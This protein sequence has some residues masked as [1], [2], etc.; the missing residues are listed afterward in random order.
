MIGELPAPLRTPVFPDWW[1]AAPAAVAPAGE[2]VPRITVI[3]PS[4]NQAPFLEAT[5]RSVLSQ[6]YPNL[7]Y[8]VVDGGSRDGSVEIIKRYAAHLSSWVS[9]PDRGQVD[10][11]LKGLARATGEWVNWINSDDL[12]APGALGRVARASAGVDV[13]AGTVVNFSARGLRDATTCRRLSALS[14]IREHLGGAKFHQPG[15]WLRREA[16]QQTGINL[17]R[18]YKFDYELLLRYLHRFPRVRY[19][20]EVLAYFRLHEE[21]KTVTQGKNRVND[22]KRE[23]VDI[24]KELAQDADF[25]AL[26]G[27]LELSARQNAW[28]M[29][30]APYAATQESRWRALARLWREVRADP[31]ARCIRHTRRVALQLLR[32]GFWPHALTGDARRRL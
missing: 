26:R 6:G 13:V 15:V 3:T 18:H 7:D 11:I 21:S 31:A 2:G 29:D 32:R 10:A 4:F 24:L 23:R 9:E 22:F 19:L 30:L 17:K 5:L 1:P 14:M 12:L 28:I 8:I 16:L 27:E 25:S 20:P